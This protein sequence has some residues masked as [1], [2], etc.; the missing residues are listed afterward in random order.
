MSSSIFADP[1]KIFEKKDLLVIE[2][3]KTYFGVTWEE[4]TGIYDLKLMLNTHIRFAKYMCAY[5]LLRANR[6]KFSSTYFESMFKIRTIY[7]SWKL[8]QKYK[9]LKTQY[10][11][12]TITTRL[13]R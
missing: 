9:C 11:R 10:E 6:Y 5:Y 13:Y 2:K 1:K 8:M 12:I 3:I 4:L 7:D